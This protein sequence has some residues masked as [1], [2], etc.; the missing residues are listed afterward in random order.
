MISILH[1]QGYLIDWV[2]F[3]EQSIKEG[4]KFKSTL[5]KIEVSLIDTFGKEYSKEVIRV[6][7]PG[8]PPNWVNDQSDGL[9][10]AGSAR[11]ATR[12]G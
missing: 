7:L 10:A 12:S 9:A 8:C 6:Q 4:W 2:D 11:A 1:E 5:V 3:I